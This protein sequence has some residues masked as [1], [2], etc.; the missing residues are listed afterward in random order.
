MLDRQAA[1]LD[2]ADD[3]RAR[4]YAHTANTRAAEQRARNELAARSVDPDTDERDTTAEQWLDAHRADQAAEDQHREI[5]DEHDLADLAEAREADQRT[6]QPDPAR[7]AAETD[8]ADVRESAAAEPKREPRTEHDWTRV[9]TADEAADSITRA[10]RA[11][12]E[13]EARTTKDQRRD[14]EEARQRQLAR[15][16]ADDQAAAASAEREHGLARRCNRRGLSRPPQL[17]CPAA[18]GPTHATSTP[19]SPSPHAPAPA[20]TGAP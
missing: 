10:Q 8:L 12:A 17:A 14:A 4:W 16:H 15:W 3:I 20:R 11:L 9:P 19:T 13:L 5:T 2:K 6:A 1:Q 7:D 18:A